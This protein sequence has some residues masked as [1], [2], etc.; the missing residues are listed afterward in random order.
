MSIDK[1]QSTRFPGVFRLP[2][3]RLLA[4]CSIRTPDGKVVV[5]KR[6]MPEGSKEVDAINA[7][8]DL[9][10]E[11]R[12]P[13]PPSTPSPLPP[14]SSS[15]VQ[16]YAKSWLATRQAKLK[17]STA[18]TYAICLGQHILP[19][20]GHLRCCDVNRHAVESWTV[21]ALSQSRQNGQ[22]YTQDSM[23]Q[24]WRVLKCFLKDMAADFDMRDPTDRV[25]PPA[26]PELEPVREQRTLDL[27]LT[28][29]LLDAARQ[30]VPDRYAEIAMLA[31]TGMRPGELYGLKWDCVDL[32]RGEVVLRRSV[33]GGILTETTKTKS[34][35]K[36]PLHPHLVEVLRD[37]RQLQLRE[38]DTGK[39]ETG[40]VFP[41]DVGT[42]RTA[43]SLHKP[44]ER[45]CAVLG[46]DVRVG[47]QV[48]RRSLNSNLVAQQVDR[49]VIRSIVGH[50]TEQMT[51]RYFGASDKQKSDA[52]ALLQV[53]PS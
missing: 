33:S 19:R 29:N 13:P 11:F 39:L 30:H 23:R 5:R 50:T 26:R 22:P 3:G 52:V 53:R 35:R 27:D 14:D 9:K 31:L 12:N 28:A 34:R 21:W 38:Q 20:L 2:D 7:V 45:V 48:L 43:N 46:L 8:A 4:K 32:S 16:D 24:W 37:H 44:F 1:M 51:A 47:N 17:P 15:T 18:T 10:E 40:L 36:V 25:S 42:P 6:V 41:S 49:L